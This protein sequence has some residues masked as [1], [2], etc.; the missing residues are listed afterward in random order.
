[1]KRASDDPSILPLSPQSPRHPKTGEAEEI[2][3]PSS[4]NLYL[5]S[6]SRLVGTTPAIPL[7]ATRETNGACLIKHPAALPQVHHHQPRSNALVLVKG[8]RT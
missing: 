2:P 3:R 6:P 1:M 8:F 4:F 5:S 7:T